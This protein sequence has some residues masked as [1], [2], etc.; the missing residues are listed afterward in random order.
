MDDVFRLSVAEASDLFAES[1]FAF[2]RLARSKAPRFIPARLD[3][4]T[5]SIQSSTVSRVPWIAYQ[6]EDFPPR[7]IVTTVKG[8]QLADGISY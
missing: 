6:Y 2:S 8:S 5:V 1:A 7:S 4:V 3:G